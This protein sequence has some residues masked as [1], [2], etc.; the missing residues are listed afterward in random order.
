MRF[1]CS[2]I[3]RDDVI[4]LVWWMVDGWW[5][6]CLEMVVERQAGHAR[7]ITGW[8]EL[9]SGDVELVL[10]DF[11]RR[12]AQSL[13]FTR[14]VPSLIALAPIRASGHTEKLDSWILGARLEE[15]DLTKFSSFY[16]HCLPLQYQSVPGSPSPRKISLVVTSYKKL[17]ALSP[18]LRQGGFAKMHPPERAPGQ[19]S[20]PCRSPCLAHRSCAHSLP[21]SCS[22]R[23]SITASLLCKDTRSRI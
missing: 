6:R 3:G 20:S 21:S 16:C 23:M 12:Q 2:L 9:H 13:I 7:P 17:F 10:C 22:R 5:S 14:R 18:N 4:N 8:A 15:T 1:N 19:Q 11:G